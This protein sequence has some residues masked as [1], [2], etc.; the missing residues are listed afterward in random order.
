M[1]VYLDKYI[2]SF[3]EYTKTTIH[4]PGGHDL[5]Q[6][7]E[8]LERLDSKKAE[9]FHH[10]VAKLLFVAERARI[11][12]EPTVLFLCTRVSKSTSEDWLK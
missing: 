2:E 1:K 7:K 11:D 5:F 4:Y 10:I 8:L 6:V 3:A 9:V 12:I